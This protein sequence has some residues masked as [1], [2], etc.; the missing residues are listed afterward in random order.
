M[1]PWD[2]GKAP[3]SNPCRST[4]SSPCWAVWVL[5]QGFMWDITLQ[6]GGPGSG[7]TCHTAGGEGRG[8]DCGSQSRWS[9]VNES[10]FLPSAVGGGLLLFFSWNF[11]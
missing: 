2:P 1:R 7:R 3:E 11:L 6:S 10:G 4:S 5:S 8:R 9:L